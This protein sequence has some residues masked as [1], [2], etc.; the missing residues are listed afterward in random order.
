[1]SLLSQGDEPE[2]AK[3]PFARFIPRALMGPSPLRILRLISPQRAWAAEF[4]G[5]RPHCAYC[6]SSWAVPTLQVSAV[7]PP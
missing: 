4:C 2:A 3:T 7:L 6:F 1:M 5:L